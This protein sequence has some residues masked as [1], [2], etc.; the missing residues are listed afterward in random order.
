MTYECYQGI[1]YR[2]NT[3]DLN[4]IKEKDYNCVFEYITRDSVILD[5]GAHIGSF[6]IRCLAH[7]PKKVMCVEPSPENVNVLRLN[8]NKA[9]N[10]GVLRCAVS[11]QDR[12]LVDA[13]CKFKTNPGY[14]LT[15]IDHIS[16][17]GNLEVAVVSLSYLLTKYRPNIVKID[18]EKEELRLNFRNLPEC[19]KVIAIEIHPKKNQRAI[20]NQLF[21]QRFILRYLTNSKL[22]ENAVFIFVRD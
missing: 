12:L 16:D 9:P 22:E 3:N 1:Y 18:I 17:D 19:V 10:V 13:K 2:P 20:V 7:N 6:T 15:T 4:I 14:K 21:A 8:L 5:V 11:G